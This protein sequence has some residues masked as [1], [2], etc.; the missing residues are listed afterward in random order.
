M[1]SKQVRGLRR[2]AE[3]ASGQIE[4]RDGRIEPIDIPYLLTTPEMALRL[5]GNSV[6][7]LALGLLV[8]RL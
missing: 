2:R 1:L 5:I 8:A 7:L 4:F 3:R 6:A